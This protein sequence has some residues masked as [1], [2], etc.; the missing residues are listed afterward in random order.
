[1]MNIYAYQRKPRLF[2]KCGAWLCAT[3]F[4][5]GG[6]RTAGLAYKDWLWRAML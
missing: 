4:V 2:R 3:P 1:M 6:G 5:T